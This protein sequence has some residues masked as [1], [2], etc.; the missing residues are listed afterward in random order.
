M[1]GGHI[2]DI[3][4][5]GWAPVS[6]AYVTLTELAEDGSAAN[7]SGTAVFTPS[8]TVYSSAVPVLIPDVPVQAQVING[9][10]KNASGG[11]LT[12]LATDN[13]GLSVQGLSG[14]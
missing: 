1:A 11:A 5:R 14:F 3:T 2:P 4:E 12:L 8:A 9:Q 6:L 13:A 10:L 7:L